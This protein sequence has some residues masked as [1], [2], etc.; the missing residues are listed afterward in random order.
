MDGCDRDIAEE[1]MVMATARGVDE[2][3]EVG[4]YYGGHNLK[5]V[6]KKVNTILF[7]F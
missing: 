2:N 6:W 3:A 7:D 5:M 4:F 1:A